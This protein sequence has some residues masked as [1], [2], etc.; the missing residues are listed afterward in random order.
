M[1]PLVRGTHGKSLVGNHSW[2][3]GWPMTSV[4]R[5]GSNLPQRKLDVTGPVWFRLQ[6][7][8]RTWTTEALEFE[9]QGGWWLDIVGH[10]LDYGSQLL[11]KDWTIPF[12][13]VSCSEQ[14]W[15]DLVLCLLGNNSAPT[16]WSSLTEQEVCILPPSG[17][18]QPGILLW[19]W[20]MART[21]AQSTRPSSSH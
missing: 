15:A 12:S 18:D 11:E 7:K 8:S 4:E 2:L 14:Q 16:S 10:S 6:S 3:L 17:R 5:H 20:L 1:S 13:G 21:S 9:F 19:Y